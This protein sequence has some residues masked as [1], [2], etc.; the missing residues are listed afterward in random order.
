MILLGSQTLVFWGYLFLDLLMVSIKYWHFR[1]K[2]EW[3]IFHHH[4]Y[5]LHKVFWKNLFLMIMHA[6]KLLFRLI[7]YLSLYH[8][9]EHFLSINII[10]E[11]CH[12]LYRVHLNNEQTVNQIMEDNTNILWNQM[13]D[14][15]I[16]IMM[17]YDEG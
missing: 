15:R 3:L 7:I 4:I 11:N 12:N 1:N 9:N 8:E 14:H 10:Q 16:M 6:P 13:D 2:Q 17:D 5:S